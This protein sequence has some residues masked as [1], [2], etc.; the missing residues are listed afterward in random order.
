M[1]VITPVGYVKLAILSVFL[2]VGAFFGIRS[3]V[4]DIIVR[5]K[6]RKYRTKIVPGHCTG[7]GYDIRASPERCPECGRVHSSPKPPPAKLL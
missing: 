3:A 6:L 7:C 2:V 1:Y 5:I 4:R